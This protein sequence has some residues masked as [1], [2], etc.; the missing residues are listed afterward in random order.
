MWSGFGFLV[1]VLGC[2]DGKKASSSG[3]AA[4][5]AGN[6][7]APVF[8]PTAPEEPALP[9]FVPCPAGWR[10]V[11]DEAGSFDTCDPWPTDGPSSCADDEAQFVGGTGCERIG[12]AC[13]A[14]DFAEGL[15]ASGVV[16]VKAGAAAGGDGSL[17]APF[18]TIAEGVAAAD[19]GDVI[20][21]SKGTF[22]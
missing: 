4:P 9:S 2:G 20:A 12:T 10:E 18:A 1:L 11:A 7:A 16:Y 14:G 22:E 5:D 19:S 21:L 8:E 17:G 15:P 13:P 6:D 3:D